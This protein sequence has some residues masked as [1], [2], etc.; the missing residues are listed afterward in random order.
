[1]TLTEAR[2]EL[3]QLEMEEF[4]YSYAMGALHYDGETGAPRDTY[5]PRGKALGS[6]AWP[7]SWPPASAVS[8]CSTR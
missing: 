8:G 6:A 7:T 3:K 4:A 1:M 5:I 2:E